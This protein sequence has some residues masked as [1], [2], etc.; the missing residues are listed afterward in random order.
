MKKLRAESTAS[1]STL[2]LNGIDE[3]I[4]TLEKVTE[5][6]RDFHADGDLISDYESSDSISKETDQKLKSSDLNNLES[7]DV[8]NDNTAFV[9]NTHGRNGKSLS[10]DVNENEIQTLYDYKSKQGRIRQ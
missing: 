9:M 6:L 8:S 2:E 7:G 1:I 10:L 5:D 3:M 4:R